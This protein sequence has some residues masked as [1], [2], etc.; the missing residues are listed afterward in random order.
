MRLLDGFSRAGAVRLTGVLVAVVAAAACCVGVSSAAAEGIRTIPVGLHP[1]GVSSDGTHVWVANFG[2]GT[3]SEIGASS[4]EVI[5]TIPVGHE[6]EGVSSDGT[7]VW[8]TNFGEDTVKEIGASSG[9][10]IRT[11]PVGHEP[12][13]V[14]SD[15]THVWVANFGEG[16]VSEIEAS[17]GE[18]INTIP[19]GSYPFGVSSDGTHVWVSNAEEDTV[20][21]IGASSGE[22]IRTIPVGG[23][24][25][26]GGVSSDGTHV[27]VADSGES[28]VKEIEASSGTLVR[29]IP[30]GIGSNL[31]DVSSDGTHVW[32]ANFGEGTVS[33]IEASSGEV[34][35]T[36]PVGSY[37]FGVSSDGIHVWVTNWG[38]NTVSEIPTSYVA[39]PKA[40]IESPASGGTYA[41]GAVVTTKF[42]CTEAKGEPGLESCTDS[43]GGSGTS[44]VLATSTLGPHTYT[45]T[46]KS[47]DGQTGTA[48]I[49][50][51]VVPPK[52]SI[53]SPASGGTYVQGAVIAT[54]FS[55]TEGPDGP[56]LESCTDSNG[57]S[58]TSGVLETSTLGPHT[59]TVTAKSKGGA[60]GT[61]SISY[62]VV[63]ASPPKASIEAPAS[64]GTYAQG[65]AVTTKFSCTEATG[66]PG[67]ESCTDSNGG[68][69]TSGVLET[70][71][72]GSH[73]YTVTAKSKDGL[74]GTA[75]ITYTVVE[76]LPPEYG[77]CVKVTS[78]KVGAKTVYHGGFT[79]ATCLVKSGTNTGQ[80]EWEPG[81][82]KAHFT[83]KMKELTKVILQTVT[84]SRVTCTGETGTGEYTGLKTVGG[85][86]LTL[87]GCELASPKATCASA[88]GA[89][90]E[91]VTKQLAGALGVDTLGKTAAQNKIGLDLFPVGKTGPLM[92]FSCAG[93]AVSV[94]GSVIVPVTANKME[95]AGTLKASAT[96]GK[97]KPENFV[98][99]PKD[100]LE[101]SLN[102]GGFGQTGLTLTT[103]QTNEEAVEVN[104]VV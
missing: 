92:E 14:S 56:G 83:T 91:I 34:I 18:V 39:P 50:Y 1:E 41:Q 49:S 79:A 57:G 71:T 77:R 27:W 85:V 22:V 65:A 59:Y 93:T 16:T 15:G 44:G 64:G 68:S 35:N 30:V 11:I 80:Y 104:P 55:C 87:T 101:E 52:A 75:S 66:G 102:G 78:E 20:S 76:A 4:G 95:L 7:H 10:V 69:G 28:T 25:S 89:P 81:V 2:E 40:S 98:G 26:L 58:G 23:G 70:S 36:I 19:V 90:G 96:T 17:S 8:V 72:V 43:N 48:S 33:E 32:V 51:T 12:R 6:P 62:A 74:T 47:K 61:A 37:P 94:Q 5:R 82:L 73:T 13:N 21:E 103:T 54:K 88:G 67:L 46:A 63:E 29:T 100:I 60:T 45:V 3:V 38:E 24:G 97:Q 9:E 53:E 84:G 42:S 31:F 86:V 99:E